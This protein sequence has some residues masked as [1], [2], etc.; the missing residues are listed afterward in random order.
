MPKPQRMHPSALHAKTTMDVAGSNSPFL[1]ELGGGVDKETR[2]GR[3]GGRGLGCM[4][5]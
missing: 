5:W 1:E 3:R 4:V 2:Q